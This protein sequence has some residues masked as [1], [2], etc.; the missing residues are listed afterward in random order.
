VR[1]WTG[2][3]IKRDATAKTAAAAEDRLVEVLQALLDESSPERPRTDLTVADVAGLWLDSPE[4]HDVARRHSRSTRRL[5]GDGWS[6]T[7]FLR[8]PSFGSGRSNRAT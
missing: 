1:L 4:R 2:E 5:R 3:I 7:G 8:S 6:P